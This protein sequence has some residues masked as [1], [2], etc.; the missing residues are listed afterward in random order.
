MFG[1]TVKFKCFLE[2]KKKRDGLRE[3]RGRISRSLLS[4]P[5]LFLPFLG[6]DVFTSGVSSQ[7]ETLRYDVIYVVDP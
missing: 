4:E 7:S 2:W 1:M 5:F 6:G 3:F